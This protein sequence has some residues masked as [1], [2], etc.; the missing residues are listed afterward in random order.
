MSTLDRWLLGRFL[1]AYLTFLVS[2]LALFWVIDLFS[3][4]E[5]L[6]RRG[7]ELTEL[8]PSLGLGRALLERYG[9]MVPELFFTLSPHFVLLAGLWVVIDLIRSNE[10]VSLLS[11]GYAPR[12][13]VAPLLIAA[14]LLGGLAWADRELLLPRLAYLRRARTLHDLETIRPLPDRRGVLTARYYEPRRQVLVQPRYVLRNQEGGEALSVLAEEAVPEGAGWRFL[15]GVVIERQEGGDV[16]RPFGGDG[17]LVKT[18]V[19]PSDVEASIDSPIYLSSEQLEAQLAR[20]PGFRHLEV[21][22]YERYTQWLAGLALLLAALPLAL[23]GVESG[24]YARV[25]GAITLG[26]GYFLLTT[27]MVELGNRG[28][29]EPLAAAFAPLLLFGAIGVV[30][31]A[32]GEA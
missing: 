11:A 6:G 25:V 12:R 5:R 15:R 26:V 8:D 28:A 1:R 20:T 3:N 16:V 32:R 4:L 23:G 27:V 19:L 13:L 17:H 24:L 10:L 2:S 30:L 29:V 31:F 21:L 22:L 7:R 9:T 14:T 18:P